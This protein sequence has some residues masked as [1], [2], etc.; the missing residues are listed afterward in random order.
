MAL[1]L[2]MPYIDHLHKVWKEANDKVRG[3][4]ERVAA[5]WAAFAAGRGDPPDTV[6]LGEVAQLRRECDEKLSAI[7]ADFTAQAPL[8]SPS[9]RPAS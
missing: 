4:E 5:A 2:P 6:L 3:A 1:P 9:D 7:L 8:P